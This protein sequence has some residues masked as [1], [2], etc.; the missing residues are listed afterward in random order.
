MPKDHPLN[1]ERNYTKAALDVLMERAE[2]RTKWSDSH[3]S[4]HDCGELA[5]AAAMLADPESE[6]DEPEKY[7]E[8]EWMYRLGAKHR[9]DRRRQLVIAAALLLAEIERIDR[10]VTSG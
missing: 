8:E 10:E 7:Q 3:D 1:D 2:Q 6:F 9:G 5:T 4:E